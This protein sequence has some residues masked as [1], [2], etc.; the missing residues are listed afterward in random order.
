MNENRDKETFRYSYSAKDQEEIRKIR[1][2]Y[3]PRDENKLEQLRQLDTSATR[4]GLIAAL[5][6]GIFGCLLLGF[7]MCC[8]LIW[9]EQY[10]IPGILIG[11]A[12]I[13]VASAAYPLYNYLTRKRR[14]KLAP[15]VLRLADE[16][17]QQ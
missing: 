17:S 11:V 1:E 7:G 9:T 12:G 16:L 3:I 10:F 5:I 13:V 14:E 6:A 8:T 15:E 2:K 4:P